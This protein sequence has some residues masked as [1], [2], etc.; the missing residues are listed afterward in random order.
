MRPIVKRVRKALLA[1]FE[2]AEVTGD[3]SEIS[4][5]SKL[6]LTIDEAEAAE[7]AAAAA[8]DPLHPRIEIERVITDGWWQRLTP[9][10]RALLDGLRRLATERGAPQATDPHPYQPV[11]S[12]EGV[13]KESEGLPKG[14]VQNAAPT[15]ASAADAPDPETCPY[16]HQSLTRCAEIQATRPDAW[17]ALHYADPLEVARRDEEATATMMKQI[18]KPIPWDY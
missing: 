2:R 1:A 7:E 8:A 5:I 14:P 18:G 12:P 11:A 17:R 10:E 16:C 9:D 15:A 13:S 4:T 6:L 3:V